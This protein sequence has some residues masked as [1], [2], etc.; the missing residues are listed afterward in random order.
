LGWLEEEFRMFGQPIGER[1]RRT[2]EAVEIMRLAWTGERFS[3]QGEIHSYDRV[4]VTPPPARDGGIRI[5]LGGSSRA[6]VRRAGE[7]GNG[8]IRSRSDV[9]N[10][11]RALALAEEGARAGGRDP[12]RLGFAQL[13]SA[14]VSEEGDAWERV[15]EGARHHIG[16][17]S[18]WDEGA[19]T[20]GKG[21][22]VSP[23]DDEELRRIVA[24]GTSDEVA[25]ELRP[26]VEA[27]GDRDEFHLVVR[28]HYPGMELDVAARCVELF[29]ERV[30]PRLRGV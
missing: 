25:T 14:F 19:D 12:R 13:K 16:I 7:L 22:W 3:Y 26:W 24:A 28:L 10:A 6:A 21:F 30:M 27:F 8:Y 9:E 2:V 23:P 17:Y 1:V 18:A 11:R 4:Q 29:A 20:P 15:Q 5:Y